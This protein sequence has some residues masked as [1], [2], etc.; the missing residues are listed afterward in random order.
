MKKMFNI[1]NRGRLELQSGQ[2]N[3]TEPTVGLENSRIA[4]YSNLTSS[5]GRRLETAGLDKIGGGVW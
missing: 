1:C 4:M 2:L 5:L 3:A